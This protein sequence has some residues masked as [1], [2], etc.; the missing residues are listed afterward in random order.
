MVRETAP[1]SYPKREHPAL[2][3]GTAGKS[4]MV[5]LADL[6]ASGLVTIAQPRKRL[7]DGSWKVLA[8]VKAISRHLRPGPQ[9]EKR[10]RQGQSAAH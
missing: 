2:D 8:A 9:A 5:P 1:A 3:S 7:P 6:K 10:T 4:G